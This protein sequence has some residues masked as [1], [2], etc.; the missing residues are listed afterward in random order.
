MILSRVFERTDLQ[1][2]PFLQSCLMWNAQSTA[3]TSLLVWN[4]A[5]VFGQ[6]SSIFDVNLRLKGKD[7]LICL[8]FRLELVQLTTPG[9]P[10]TQYLPETLRFLLS[11]VFPATIYT[12]DDVTKTFWPRILGYN[13][14]LWAL[15]KKFFSALWENSSHEIW[16]NNT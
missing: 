2:R 3:P 6:I 14:G 4:R 11:A 7:A 13:D 15:K 8:E 12:T 9:P 1:G 5:G 10:A 16:S